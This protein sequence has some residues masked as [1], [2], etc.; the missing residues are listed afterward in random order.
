MFA[1][2]VLLLATGALHVG[3]VHQD[4]GAARNRANIN[5]HQGTPRALPLR[6]F[7]A[8][9]VRS[10]VLAR[11]ELLEARVAAANFEVGHKFPTS[12]ALVAACAGAASVLYAPAL[13]LT[14]A[15]VVAGFAWEGRQ[16]V[17][18]HD[19]ARDASFAMS[20]CLQ[21][22]NEAQHSDKIVFSQEVAE[23]VVG[24]MLEAGLI[25]MG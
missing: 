6:F 9:G 12:L 2:V 1:P 10:F 22:A 16:I 13:L 3:C 17:R 21:V 7:R 15:A 24:H 8:P 14:G 23:L 18:R 11:P 5:M 20:E 19:R 25:T 4:V